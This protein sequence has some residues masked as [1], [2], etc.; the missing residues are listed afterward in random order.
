MKLSR[1]VILSQ[2]FQK[3]TGYL[4]E[5]M[6]FSYE[7]NGSDMIILA[8]EEYYFRNNTAQ[9]NIIVATVDYN[10]ITVDII[11]GA[12]GAGLLNFSLGSEKN[13]IKRALRLIDRYIEENNLE[14]EDIIL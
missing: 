9:L 12:G 3:F 7:N 8:D 10:K 14:S 13:F 11:G 6:S 5:N 2:D 4:K 1:I